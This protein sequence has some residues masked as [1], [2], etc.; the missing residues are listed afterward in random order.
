MCEGDE[1]KEKNA[2]MNPFQEFMSGTVLAFN[3][4]H[5]G[6]NNSPIN[7]ITEIFAS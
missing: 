3:K 1:K 7:V 2:G 6:N 4:S 5:M